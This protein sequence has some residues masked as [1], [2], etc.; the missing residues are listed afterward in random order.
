MLQKSKLRP[1]T[2]KLAAPLPPSAELGSHVAVLA[3]SQST[4]LTSLRVPR[5]LSEMILLSYNGQKSNEGNKMGKKKNK[6][7]QR[8]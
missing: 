3:P 1:R 8:K 4:V 5:N 2:P 6:L 7:K